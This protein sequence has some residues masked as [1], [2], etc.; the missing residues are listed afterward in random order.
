MLGLIGVIFV[1]AHN[2]DFESVQLGLASVGMS[3]IGL[4]GLTAGNLYQKKY[5][6]EMNI[7]SGG[8]IQ[9]LISGLICISL[10]PFIGGYHVEWSNEFIG[11][12]IYMSIGVSMGALSILILMIRRD[13]VS[14]VASVFYLVPVSAAIAAY[15]FFDE[16]F[17]L[18]TLT[19]IFFVGFGTFLTNNPQFNLFKIKY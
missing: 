12:L 11:A 19:G 7:F 14:K 6:A 18:H 9:S 5:C 10:L 15:F 16:T 4:L 1:V 13:D 2:I 17:D 3:V 8:A